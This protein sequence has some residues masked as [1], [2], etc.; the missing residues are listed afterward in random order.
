[1]NKKRMELMAGRAARL[2]VASVDMNNENC[3]RDLN[4]LSGWVIWNPLDDNKQAFMLQCRMNI[5][6]R[7]ELD[8]IKAGISSEGLYC[9]ISYS[10][11]CDADTRS[12]IVNVAYQYQRERL[13]GQ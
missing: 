7:Y 4:S 5:D 1:M 12:A 8:G 6:I 13:M 11:D 2:P 3:I 10:G 9:F